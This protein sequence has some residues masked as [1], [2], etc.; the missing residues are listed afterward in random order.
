MLASARS[1]VS[2]SSSQPSSSSSSSALS[3][4]AVA[5]AAA[6]LAAAPW[7]EAEESSSMRSLR[8]LSGAGMMV[9]WSGAGEGGVSGERFRVGGAG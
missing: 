2:L 1:I 3:N 5:T 7:P 4:S 9:Y 8:I 6:A